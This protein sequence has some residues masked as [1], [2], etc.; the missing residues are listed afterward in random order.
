MIQHHHTP[1]YHEKLPYNWTCHEEQENIWFMN[2][3]HYSNF[4]KIKISKINGLGNDPSES[5]K[6]YYFTCLIVN[7]KIHTG[8]EC[9]CFTTVFGVN[10]DFWK[11]G[12]RNDAKGPSKYHHTN[13]LV[14][15]NQQIYCWRVRIS[16][17]YEI[18]E[19]FLNKTVGGTPGIPKNIAFQLFCSWW[20]RKYMYIH[21]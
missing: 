7:L 17:V 1:I 18:I 10:E 11:V 19:F 16:T 4:G 3:D 8:R 21:V 13:V 9:Y 2:G 15:R 12:A 14:M 5:L 20:I 6:Y